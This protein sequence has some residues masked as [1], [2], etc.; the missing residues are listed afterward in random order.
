VT[1]AVAG[2]TSSG[3]RD[4]EVVVVAYRSAENVVELLDSLGGHAPVVVIDNCQGADG[5]DELV[6]DRPGVRYLS[7]PGR[8][9]AAGANLGIRT[10]RYGVVVLAGPDSRPDIRVLDALAA[11][12]ADPRV[13]Q[14]CAMARR[15]DGRVELGAAGW[16]PTWWRALVHASGL[17]YLVPRAG[18]W[19]RPE[20]GSHPAIDWCNAAVAAIDRAQFLELG[21]LDESFFVYSEDVDFGRRIRRAGLEQRLRTDLLVLHGSGTSGDTPDR[22]S[23]LR[24]SSTMIDVARHH[25]RFETAAIRAILAAGAGA[26]AAVYRLLRRTANARWHE[27]YIRGLR[28]GPPDM[29]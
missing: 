2:S 8:G 15:P 13:V 20:P 9:F 28:F 1:A 10:S 26:R 16:E 21:G 11:D 14:S 4:Y 23:R 25:G 19:A 24:G 22:M 6:R 27:A 7:G 12:V 29:T 18:L 17:H 5:L 3:M